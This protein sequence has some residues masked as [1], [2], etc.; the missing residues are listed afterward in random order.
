M[1]PDWGE[2]GP[3]GDTMPPSRLALVEKIPLNSHSATT[4]EPRRVLASLAAL[5][6]EESG[7]PCC[8]TEWPQNGHQRIT[9]DS[10]ERRKWLTIKQASDGIR[11]HDLPITNRLH[12]LCATLAME[13]RDKRL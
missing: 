4:P 2:S 3:P 10:G 12:Y 8:R 7:A 1:A 13:G 9:L 6:C 11:T 5:A